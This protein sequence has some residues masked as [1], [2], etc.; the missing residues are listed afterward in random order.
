MSRHIIGQNGAPLYTVGDQ[1]DHTVAVKWKSGPRFCQI[2]GKPLVG[3][4]QHYCS[5]ECKAEGKRRNGRYYYDKM[6]EYREKAK[7]DRAT[8][9]T[10]CLCCGQ[11]IPKGRI[12]FCSDRCASEW[13]SSLA[14]Q[15]EREQ[16]AEQAERE[17]KKKRS[18]TMTME[19]VLKGMEETGMQYGEY[20]ARYEEGKK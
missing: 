3:R 11:P 12:V 15:R 17:A 10:S 20:V 7:Q 14:K 8:K 4:Q 9:R 6:H 18:K 2:C 13:Q 19:Q 1:E 16:K 5:T